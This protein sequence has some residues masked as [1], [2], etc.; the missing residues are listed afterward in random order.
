MLLLFAF[1]PE[2]G[3]FRESIWTIPEPLLLV[4]VGISAI[5]CVVA[6]FSYF[7]A[8]IKQFKEKYFNKK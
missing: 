2:V 8:T 6:F 5:L 3:A 1:A 4:L 7:P